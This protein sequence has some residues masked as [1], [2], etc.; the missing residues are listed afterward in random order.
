[1]KKSISLL[2]AALLTAGIVSGVFAGGRADSGAAAGGASAGPGTPMAGGTLLIGEYIL[3][4]QLAARNP[5]FPA[6][7]HMGTMNFIYERLM[8][9]NPIL[10]ELEPEIATGYEWSDNY[11]TLTFTI[12]D[13]NT[14]H[15]G[16]P[17]SA[18]DVAFTYNVLKQYPVTDRFSLWNKISSVTAQ[19]NK[20][21][22][23]L[24]QSFTSLPFYTNDIVIVPK[25]IW[26]PVPNIAEFLN[27]NPVGSGP[28]TWGTYNTGTDIQLKANKNYWRG[29]PKV[30]NLIIRMYNNAPNCTLG[31]LRQDVHATLGT[32][33][34]ANL[35]EILSRP[36]A[37]LQKYAGFSNYQVVLNLENE[38]LADVNVRKAMT[39]AINTNDLIIRGE[40]NGVFPTSSGWLPAI[41]G[42]LLSAEARKDHVYDPAEAMRILE[43]AGYTKGSDG[44][45][46]KNGKRL[47]FTYHNASGAPAQQMEAG[48]IQQW[49]LNIGIEIIP[50]LATWPELT[51]LAQTGRFNLLQMGIGFPGDPYAALNTSFHSSMTAPTGQ[52][53]VGTNYF[54]YRNPR[55]D[56]L[57]DEVSGV[58]D[59]AKQRELYG[60]I[61]D[62]L[63]DEVPF[64]PMYNVG[65]HNPYY[66]GGRYGG[67]VE[68]API[69]CSRAIIQVYEIK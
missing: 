7:T 44:I 36:N 39:L 17:V 37:K 24:S 11:M 42:E 46:Q 10:G 18:E 49:L 35:P 57:L 38:L 32:I 48:M 22:F 69:F 60:Q 51:Q 26:E 30:D 29:A 68:D 23:T 14:W 31:L 63:I 65:G 62:I 43:A 41:F 27:P 47:S 20:V 15:D 4:T 34:M 40:Y 59:T 66:D 61:Q 2:M 45:Y 55:V 12:R 16:R 54:R 6:N 25:H 19:G 53:T 64:L 28:F 56:A 58:V 9:F 13:N 33:A 52:P 21:V 5:F 67:W 1:M 50:R 8:F 3:D